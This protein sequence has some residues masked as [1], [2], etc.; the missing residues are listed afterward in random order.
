M[1][2]RSL[3]VVLAALLLLACS[4]PEDQA[5]DMLK[6]AREAIARR[7][8]GAARGAAEALRR[9][10]PATAETLVEYATLLVEAGEAAQAVWV[11]EEAVA[12]FPGSDALR[13]VFAQAALSSGE[14]ARAQVALEATTP[15]SP[16]YA[17]ALATRAQAELALGDVGKAR[18]TLD[19]ATKAAGP[20]VSRG[21]AK[22]LQ[23]TLHGVE[24]LEGT[25]DSGIAELRGLVAADPG[26]VLAWSVLEQALR[27]SGRADEA[28]ELLQAALQAEPDRVT[29]HPLLA[30]AYVALGDDAAAER[31]LRERIERH[32]SPGAHRSLARFRSSLGDKDMALARYALAVQQFPNDAMSSS[33]RTEALLDIGNVPQARS[34]F[35]RYKKLAAAGPRAEY[36]LARIELAEGD[37]FLALHRL[38]GLVEKLDSPSTQYWLGNAL[39]ATENF[40]DAEKR[41]RLAALRNPTDPNPALALVRLARRRGDWRVVIRYAHSAIEHGP[42]RFEGWDALVAAHL[43]L[44]EWEQAEAVARRAIEQFPDRI[45]PHLWLANSLRSQKRYD[46]A[47]AALDEAE[48]LRVALARKKMVM[49]GRRRARQPL[50]P[51]P[52]AAEIAVQRALTLGA[53][54]KLDEGI[55]TVERASA[56]HPDHARLKTALAALLF[57]K[58]R[59]REAYRAIGRALALD[60]EDLRP[61]RTRAEFCLAR[62]ELDQARRDLEAYL[63]RRP[64]DP[65]IHYLL[66]WLHQVED[67]HADAVE[68]YRRAAELDELNW[69]ARSFMAQ[70]LANRDKLGGALVAAEEAY[71]VAPDEPLVM[72]TL[73][74]IYLHMESPRRSVPLLEK[75]H[76]EAPEA[77]A[78]QLHLAMAY[79]M[80]GRTDEARQLLTEL[81]AHPDTSPKLKASAEKALASLR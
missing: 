74:L 39:E 19:A 62:K 25:G 13:V 41:Y 26:D 77:A 37:T 78:V 42:D 31:V 70:L 69:S 28:R 24:A 33:A 64:D 65:Y 4:S 50:P 80:A 56:D 54:G 16:V 23:V 15:E 29:L 3:G 79:R 60:P 21:L 27:V 10:R 53:S 81:A 63:D 30:S 72:S 5:D 71:A 73:G 34:E 45:E 2:F 7:D 49:M 17:E 67:R 36:L 6:K 35:R 44:V 46:D 14:P 57:G 11:L 22:R 68:A 75:A 9:A 76:A 48:T 38:D 51:G 58:G 52:E 8:W 61:L 1:R 55:E 40:E 43:W 59:E 12:R 66:G 20:E 18:K 32:P 47:L